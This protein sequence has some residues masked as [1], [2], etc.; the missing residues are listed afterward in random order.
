SSDTPR[1]R[2]ALFPINPILLNNMPADEGEEDH[3]K[4]VF[5]GSTLLF[6]ISSQGCNHKNRANS[7]D[8]EELRPVIRDA[9]GVHVGCS[10]RV[11]ELMVSHCLKP[12]GIIHAGLS[13]LWRWRYQRPPSS[14]NLKL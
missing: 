14:Q 1:F 6:P 12:A 3:E 9:V 4:N 13:E 10:F 8:K 11:P 7:D 2:A 5:H